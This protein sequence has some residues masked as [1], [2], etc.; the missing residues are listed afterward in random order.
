MSTQLV[1]WSPQLLS[2][3]RIMAGL[4][5]MEHG[6]MKL[7]DFPAPAP[8]GLGH[9][10]LLF[11]G[12]LETFGGAALALGLFTRLVAFLLSG[13][14]AVAYWMFHGPSNFYP[15][16]NMGEAAVL[17]CFVFLYI[18]AAGPGAWSIDALIGSGAAEKPARA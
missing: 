8:P 17:Y 13:E 10:L 7:F 3:M 12:I 6:T 4:L 1:R 14:M 16:A 2:V 15:I 5:F 11:T 9:G 18:A